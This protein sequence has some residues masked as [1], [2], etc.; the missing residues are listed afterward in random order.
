MSLI[1]AYH[2]NHSC[3]NIFLTHYNAL[4]AILWGRVYNDI[5]TDTNGNTNEIWWSHGYMDNVG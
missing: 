1:W 4:C 2:L 3:E 5:P